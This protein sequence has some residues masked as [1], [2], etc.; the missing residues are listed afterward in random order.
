MKKYESPT[1]EILRFEEDD[2]IRTSGGKTTDNF[3]YDCD[4]NYGQDVFLDNK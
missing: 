1:A 4:W 2:A 3:G